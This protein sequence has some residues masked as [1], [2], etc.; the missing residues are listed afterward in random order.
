[1]FTIFLED[2]P[3]IPSCP[4]VIRGIT[5]PS[6]GLSSVDLSLDGTTHRLELPLGTY[7]YFVFGKTKNCT[8]KVEIKGRWVIKFFS[9]NVGL[10]KNLR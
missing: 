6:T 10:S 3:D 1:M 2:T 5:S 8:L 4:D 7:N 9:L